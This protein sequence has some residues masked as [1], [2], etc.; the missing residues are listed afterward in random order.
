MI[1]LSP[2]A[3]QTHTRARPADTMRSGML[4]RGPERDVSSMWSFTMLF[5]CWIVIFVVLFVFLVGIY[6]SYGH[7]A[8][9]KESDMAFYNDVCLNPKLLAK[10][11]C[12]ERCHEI[13]D[14]KGQNTIALAI[15]HT[16]QSWHLCKMFDCGFISHNFYLIVVGL[17]LM[18]ATL[19]YTL[20]KVTGGLHNTRLLPMQISGKEHLQ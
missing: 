20:F 1:R 18:W 3:R 9:T 12:Y 14:M 4:R 16:A 6:L 10:Y 17:M 2:C 19:L 7:I 11:K 5:I 8:H 15:L 13:E